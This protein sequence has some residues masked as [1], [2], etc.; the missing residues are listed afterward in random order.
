MVKVLKDEKNLLDLISKANQH[1]F[2][3]LFNLYNNKVYS[4]AVKLLKSEAAAEEVVQDVFL[5]IWVN[6]ENLP[7]IQNF[8]GYLRQ[9]TRNYALTAL[10]KI[11]RENLAFSRKNHDW[12]DIDLQTE[13]YIS[14]KEIQETLN[15]A[16]ETLPPQ[17]KLIFKMCR[18]EGM[19]QAEV[20]QQ[21]D[22]SIPTVK[23]HLR[24]AS[25]TVKNYMRLH[26]DLG[27]I[28]FFISVNQVFIK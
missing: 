24:L 6:K 23:T 2:R 1:A 10:R 16:L 27:L 8:G 20:A 26:G 21:L 25:Q 17:Q 19:K 11:A 12:K 13:N 22:I 18:L 7:N 5:N 9:V 4:Y 14:T 15:Q 3:M 28:V